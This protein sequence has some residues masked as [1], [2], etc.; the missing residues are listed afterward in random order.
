MIWP[1][2]IINWARK[3]RLSNTAENPWRKSIKEYYTVLEYEAE[4]LKALNFLAWIQA[5][6]RNGQL[7]KPTE[8]LQL[9]Q[10]AAKAADYKTAEVMDTL[11]VAYAAAGDF[12]QAVIEADKA[13]TLAEASGDTALAQRIAKR[14]GL[15]HGKTYNE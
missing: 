11:A 12:R 3:K 9:A 4:N 14:R 15:F 2:P 10:R 6:S 13:I 5:T 1:G 7:R 8:A